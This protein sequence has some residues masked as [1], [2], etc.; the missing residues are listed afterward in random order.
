[1]SNTVSLSEKSALKEKNESV[2]LARTLCLIFVVFAVCWSPY[3]VIV[4]ADRYDTF[5]LELHIFSVL[6]AHTN[7]SLNSV[8]YGLT[9]KHFR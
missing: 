2:K 5:P 4:V 9:N 6:I 7:S 8:L 1:M 3:A